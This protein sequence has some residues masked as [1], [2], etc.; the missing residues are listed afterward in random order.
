MLFAPACLAEEATITDALQKMETIGQES[1]THQWYLKAEA[2]KARVNLALKT[3]RQAPDTAHSIGHMTAY[4]YVPNDI[5]AVY[6]KPLTVTDIALQAG[7][8]ISGEIHIGDTARWSITIGTT[9]IGETLK[10]HLYIKPNQERLLTNLIIPTNKR[11]YM[12]ELSSTKSFYMPSVTWDY[13]T[14]LKDLTALTEIPSTE[15]TPVALIAPENL[16][17][18]YEM[19][20]KDR[21]KSWSP[22]QIFDDG[23]KTYLVFSEEMKH[24]DTPVIY[25]QSAAGDLALVNFRVSMPYYIV[26]GLMDEIV[27]KRGHKGKDEIKISRKDTIG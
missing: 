19:R 9:G 2:A 5:F 3:A 12:V 25:G 7:E 15:P 26:D 10:Q 23:E 24:R 21:S 16:Y 17:F 4:Y 13:Q 22:L 27:L 14:P 18:G 20:R 6:T 1:R 11:T 8:E